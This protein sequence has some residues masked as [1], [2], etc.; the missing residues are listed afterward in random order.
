MCSSD[1]ITTA[2]MPPLSA[3]L[4]YQAWVMDPAGARSAGLLRAAPG[5]RTDPVLAA[6]TGPGD[7]IGITVEPAGGTARPTTT[8]VVTMALGA[9]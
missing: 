1:P 7:R 9:P 4:V 3:N 5:G 6:E 8:P 2:G